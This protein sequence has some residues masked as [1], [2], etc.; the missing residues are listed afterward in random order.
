MLK[1]GVAIHQPAE[2][3]QVFPLKN[4]DTSILNSSDLREVNTLRI[5]KNYLIAANVHTREGL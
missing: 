3:K 5:T 2:C 1:A 4:I